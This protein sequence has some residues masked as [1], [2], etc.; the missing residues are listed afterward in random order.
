[1]TSAPQHFRCASARSASL[2]AGFT[3][4]IL[5]ETVG[6]HL[7]LVG[8]HPMLAWSLT[9]LSVL[10]IA[11]LVSDYVA[12][13]KGGVTIGAETVT[14][15]IGRRVTTSIARADVASV[16]RP[17]W[18]DIPETGSTAARDFLNPTKPAQPNV[19]FTLRSPHTIRIGPLSRTVTRIAL[20]VDEP[21][22]FLDA[23]LPPG[24]SQPSLS[25]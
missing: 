11:Y 16:A 1:M 15:D 6:L 13:G 10:T 9:A 12:L 23:C 3:F 19:L 21:Q 24:A 7:W 5:V 22:K 18:R 8:R 14:L 4:A 25:A 17:D 2:T 20:H